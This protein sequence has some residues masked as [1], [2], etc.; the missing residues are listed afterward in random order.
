MLSLCIYVNVLN[1]Q[2]FMIGTVSSGLHHT[3]VYSEMIYSYCIDFYRILLINYISVFM[4]ILLINSPQSDRIMHPGYDKSH[5]I[6]SAICIKP[7]RRLVHIRIAYIVSL[8]RIANV[9]NS[10]VNWIFVYSA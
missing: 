1:N 3:W 6:F 2:I 7:S 8:A 9:E 10:A 5:L 4:Y